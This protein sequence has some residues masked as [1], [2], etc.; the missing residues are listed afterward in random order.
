AFEKERGRP[1]VWDEQYDDQWARLW[2]APL[3]EKRADEAA[4]ISPAK[5]HVTSVVWGPDSKQ[6]AFAA[7]P[8]PTLR[9]YRYGAV[10]VIN[11]SGGDPRQVTSMP[12]GESP[13]AWTQEN[14]L[15]VSGTGKELGTFNQQLWQVPLSGG[16]PTSLTSTLDEHAGFVAITKKSLLVEAGHHTGRR[17]YRIPFKNGRSSPPTVLTDDRQFYRSFSATKDGSKVAF[18]A[19]TWKSPPDVY[20]SSTSKLRPKRLTD[21]NP[22]VSQFQLGEQRV[23]QWKSRADGETIEGILTLPVGYTEGEKVPLLLVI[24]GGPAGVSVDRFTP[25]RGA[26]PVQVF[27]GQGYAILQPNYRG[28]TGYGERFGG[29][30]RG[31]I[32]GRDWIDNDS[33]VDEMVRQGIADPERLGIMGWSFGGHHTYWGITQ[34]DRYKAASAGAGA[35]DLISMYSQTDIP[36]FYQT[37]LGPRPWENFELY[38]Q[39]SAY[40]FVTKVSTPLLIQVGEKDERVPAEQSIQFYEAIHAIGNAETKLIVYPGQPHGIREPRLRRDLMIRNLEW[41][42]RFIP[43]AAGTSEK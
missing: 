43:V 10:Y 33:G 22:Q 16:H 4:R 27:A 20:F 28:S 7:R 21:V 9:T 29:L 26:Y 2:V 41:F 19:E 25:S 40:R 17:L 42:N 15:I 5:L 23:V 1:I 24:H 14:G 11:S 37:Y 6:I 3:T 39:R 36:E 34:T 35:N 18:L 8:S 32:S 12:G 38:E 13:V 30:N 31:D